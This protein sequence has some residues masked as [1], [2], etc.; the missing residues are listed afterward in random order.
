VTNWRGQTVDLRFIAAN[1]YSLNSNFFL[2]DVSLS[3]TAM[4]HDSLNFVPASEFM[5]TRAT[6]TKEAQQ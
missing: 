5:T 6:T 2:D 1:D 3:T 4:P